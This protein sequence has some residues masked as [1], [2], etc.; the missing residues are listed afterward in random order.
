[1]NTLENILIIAG[2]SLDVFASMEIQGAMLQ[3]VNKKTLLV[4]SAI[5]SLLQLMFFFGGYAAGY[6]IDRA[7]VWR[8]ASWV[9]YILDTIIF[10]LLGARLIV[11]GIR[12]KFV[13]E[14]RSVITV[15]Q[16]AKIIAVTTVYTLF[17]GCAYGLV[18]THVIIMLA[19]IVLF[20]FI[21]VI[22]GLYAGYHFGFEGKTVV[23][24]VG[25][26]ILWVA[27]AE[28]LITNVLVR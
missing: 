25:G 19:L 9:G 10:A 3:K 12:R 6:G 13:D 20:S 26:I 14:T 5:V 16:Y 24:V 21:V 11:K 23:Y 18:G 17:A 27:G 4:V 2:I 28:I 22:S 15:K 1:M 7:G 8:N